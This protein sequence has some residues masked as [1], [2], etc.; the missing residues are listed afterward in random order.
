M[1]SEQE[2]ELYRQLRAS[3]DKY[4]YFLLAAVGASIAFALSQTQGMTLAISQIPLGI[5]IFTWGL[6]FFFGCLHLE[7]V[8]STL[9]ANITMLKIENGNHPEVGN[10]P[11]LVAAASQGIRS[12][13]EANITCASRYGKLQFMF[14]II[15]VVFYISW[16]AI[17][18]WL[19]GNA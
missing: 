6:S 11:Q 14:F 19:R 16:H 17:E 5:G 9:Y 4:V 15:G 2:M 7:Y 8:S 10:H 13:I 12:A 18:M 1:A 3:Q